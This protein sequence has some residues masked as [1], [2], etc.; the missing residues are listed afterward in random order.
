M[1]NHLR[2]SAFANSAPNIDGL[3]WQVYS[4]RL[5]ETDSF[6][7]L[8]NPTYWKH[9]AGGTHSL[10][11]LDKVRLIA[12]D[13]SF[14]VEITI[15]EIVPG[16]AKIRLLGGMLPLKYHGMHSDEIRNILTKNEA[17]FEVV[18]LTSDGKAIPRVEQ[19]ATGW[20]VI[21]NEN[22]VVE[23]SIKSKSVADNRL[24]RYLRE[25]SLRMPTPAEAHAHAEDIRARE[26]EQ[27]RAI[28]KKSP[29][30]GHRPA[31]AEAA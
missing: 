2:L 29:S 27:Q 10:R 26:L 20:R 16:G 8:F 15:D 9:H 22:E 11:E 24:D 19:L 21:G 23:H 25:I 30:P 7:D 5:D 17:E 1:A 18:K 31:K 28:A 3:E 4:T 6:E 13:K 14:D 12:A